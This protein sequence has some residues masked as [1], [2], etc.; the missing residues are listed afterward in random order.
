MIQKHP[1]MLAF[2]VGSDF[3]PDDRATKIYVD[4]L[5]GAD[6]QLPIVPSASKRGFPELLGRSGMKMEGPYDWV[7]PNY[8][9]DREP[10]KDRFG[11]AFG[12][13]S[14]LGAGVGTPEIGSLKRFLTDEDIND[15]WKE[16]S[17][18]L[19]HMSTNDSSFYNRGIYNQGLFKRYGEPT[20]LEDYL[21]KAQIMDYE[22]TR[23]QHEA[24][25]SFWSTG[26]IATGMIY[27]MLVNAWPSLHWNQFDNY[28]HPAGSYFGSKTGSR[29]EH[30]SYNYEDK[31]I[32]L[33]NHSLDRK[34]A[35]TVEVEVVNLGG[36]TLASE[37]FDVQTTPNSAAKVDAAPGLEKAKDVVFLRLILRDSDGDALSRN[38]YWIAPTVDELNWVNSTWYYTP[39]LWYANYTSLFEMDKA[40]IEASSAPLGDEAGRYTV[41]LEN[42]SKVPAFFIRLNIVNDNGD[43]VNP[44]TWSDNYVTLWPK[45]KIQLDL[46][47]WGGA[48][49]QVHIDGGNVA[50]TNISLRA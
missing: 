35:R 2:L 17:K 20:S 32:W 39:V 43:D 16:P 13:G 24:F 12:F 38:V 10:A 6:W 34:G 25:S 41:V 8:W 1:S 50:A 18:G 44:V 15:L 27:W 30:V 45:E 28:L 14:E 42:Q 36:K 19:Y 47:D 5:R 21:R 40:S 33:I 7:P 49:A 3:W 48:A 46:N 9:Y 37:T 4:A 22:S 11:A 29:F 31:N 23:A 26:R